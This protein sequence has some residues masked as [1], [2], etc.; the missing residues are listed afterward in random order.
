MHCPVDYSLCRQAVT[1]Y[2]KGKDTVLRQVVQ[3]CYFEHRVKHTPAL[4]GVTQEK[5]FLLIMPGDTQRVFP[6][7]R[8]LPGVGPVV[9]DWEHFIPETVE[10]LV[11]VAYAAPCYWENKLCH[12]EAGR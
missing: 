12:V 5:N 6:G 10:G 7:D 11:E 1:V 8:V 4:P 3:G 2:R 9:T